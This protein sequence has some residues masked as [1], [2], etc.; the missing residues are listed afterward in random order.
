MVRIH[1]FA[2]AL[3]LSRKMTVARCL[4]EMTSKNASNPISYFH[5]RVHTLWYGIRSCS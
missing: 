3:N 1:E 5:G 4:K 2:D